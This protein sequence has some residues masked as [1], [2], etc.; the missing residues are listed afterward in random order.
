MK[1]AGVVSIGALVAVTA[2]APT[3]APAQERQTPPG[4][5]RVEVPLRP[6]TDPAQVTQPFNRTVG[7]L[8]GR[9]VRGRWN[10]R[11]GEITAVLAGEDATPVAVALDASGYAAASRPVV[12]PL[13]QIVDQTGYA[14]VTLSREQ[15]EALPRWD[16]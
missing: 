5:S 11:V 7:E 10:A 6:V 12:L 8:V 9:E 15:L 1:V 4:Y 13:E 14:M 3:H 16:P 2:A